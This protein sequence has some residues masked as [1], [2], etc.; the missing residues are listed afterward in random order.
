VRPLALAPASAKALKREDDDGD[1]GVTRGRPHL[2]VGGG[3]RGWWLRRGWLVGP[4]SGPKA[5]LG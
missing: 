1:A 2:E 4:A 3:A 5:G